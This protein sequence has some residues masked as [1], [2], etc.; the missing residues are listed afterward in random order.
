MSIYINKPDELTHWGIKGQKW[1]ERRYQNEDGTLTPAGEKRYAKNLRKAE[2]KYKGAGDAA[3]RAAFYKSKG[4]EASSKYD[5]D[6]EVLNKAAKQYDKEGKIL[7]AEATRRLAES[8]KNK[9]LQARAEYDEQAKVWL[10][11]SEYLKEKAEKFTSK[12]NVDVG[13]KRINS[14]MKEYEKK[15]FD[16]EKRDYEWEQTRNEYSQPTDKVNF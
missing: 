11:R 9:G 12:K 15:G 16:S 2:R 8:V 14:I 7:R 5:R 13:K 10:N 6:A 1:G 4:D 3:G